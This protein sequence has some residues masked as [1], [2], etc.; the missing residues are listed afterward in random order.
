MSCSIGYLASEAAFLAL[1]ASAF[2]TLVDVV[3]LEALLG[4]SAVAVLP[5][6]MLVMDAYCCKLRFVNAGLGVNVAYLLLEIET[7][8]AGSRSRSCNASHCLVFD[9]CCILIDVPRRVQMLKIDYWIVV[10]KEQPSLNRSAL[11]ASLLPL[12]S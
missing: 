7:A 6:R 4:G 3:E 1:I 11:S 2:D 5:P 12:S 9:D 10:S 8:K